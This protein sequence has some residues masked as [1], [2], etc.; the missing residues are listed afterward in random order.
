MAVASRRAGTVRRRFGGSLA[1]YRAANPLDVLARE[2]FPTT[3]A[4]VAVGGQDALYRPAA[5]ALA[6]G[7]R[8]AG[9]TV[10]RATAPGRHSWVVWRA[11]LAD[12]LP[13][14]GHR[15]GLTAK[16]R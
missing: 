11:V 10:R 7:L 3:A 8:S 1:A 15:L 13:W 2:R 4:V 5:D 12:E 16:P 6:A 9:A 14:L